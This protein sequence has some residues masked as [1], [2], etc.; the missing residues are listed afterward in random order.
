MYLKVGL[1]VED[2]DAC[3]FL[4]RNCSQDEPVRAYRLTRMCFGLACSPYLAINVIKAHA[5]RNPEECDE[6]IKRALSNMYVDD[7]VISCDEESEVAELNRRVPVFL[8]RGGFHLKKWAGNRAELL[9]TLPRTEVSKIGDRELGKALS[10]YWLKD[11]DVITFKP[12]TDS[13]T[14]TRATKR[15]RLSLAAKAKMMFQWLWT[16]GLSWDSPLPPKISK[17]WRRWQEELEKLPEVKLSRPWIP[18]AASQMRRIELHVFGDAS[19]AAYAACAYLRVESMDE[20]ISVRLMIAKTRVT[21]IKPISL[22]RL[23][24]V[25]A[26]LCARLKRLKE[27]EPFLDEDGLLRTGGRLRQSTLP[28]ESKH[29]IL[30]PSHHPVVELLIRNQ[31]I[32]QL[33]ASVNQTLVAIRTRFW[34]IKAINTVKKVIRPCPIC[35]RINAEPYQPVERV[36]ELHHSAIL[37]WTLPVHCILAQIHVPAIPALTKRI[38]LPSHIWSTEWCIWKSAEWNEVQSKLNEERTEQFLNKRLSWGQSRQRWPEPPQLRQPSSLLAGRTAVGS[39]LSSFR[40]S[41]PTSRIKALMDWVTSDFSSFGLP[42]H[43]PAV[44]LFKVNNYM[45]FTFVFLGKCADLKKL[46]IHLQVEITILNLSYCFSNV[47]IFKIAA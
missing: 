42:S 38:F 12:P 25:A 29:P 2:R 47:E 24:L 22:P 40:E 14:Q 37:V 18:H 27:F 7:L 10:V 31:H 8:K 39:S 41:L 43:I 30:L 35:R 21:P 13:T 3:R 1:R 44:D 16:T 46:A 15:Q 34:I 26:L 28:P 36:E 5:E 11:E 23:E 9:A 17:Q 6:I 19:K 4:W 33:H 20:Q 32:R 45:Q